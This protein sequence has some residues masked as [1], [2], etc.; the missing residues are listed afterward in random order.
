MKKILYLTLADSVHDQRFMQTLAE[1][2]Y[3]AYTLRV[4]RG[5]WPSPSG[6][7]AINPIGFEFPLKAGESSEFTQKLSNILCELQPDLVQ[8]GPL[9]DLAYFAVLAGAKNLLAQ[10]WGFDLMAESFASA[11]NLLR[12]KFVLAHAQG[13]MV[14]A[15]CSAEKAIALGFP[16]EKIY[17]FPWGVDLEHFSKAAWQA[18]AVKIRQDLGWENAKILFCL[19]SWEAK[20]GVADLCEAF[21]KAAASDPSLRLLLAGTGSQVEEIQGIIQSA[22][23]EDKVKILGRLPNAELPRYFAAAD[24]YVSPSHVDGSSVSLMEA[25]AMSLPALVTDIPAN[26][27][28]VHHGENGWVYRDGNIEDLTEKILTASQAQLEPLGK[29]ARCTAIQKADWQKNKQV[30]LKAWQDLLMKDLK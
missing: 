28:W 14:D 22:R 26:L 8:V 17:T 1:S 24:I 10:S 11:E 16:S 12:T 4:R 21:V 19:R 23:L 6:V 15:H 29:A 27:E 3:E 5:D 9:H 7:Q 20:Y 25:L 13:L 30:L 18:E 2:G